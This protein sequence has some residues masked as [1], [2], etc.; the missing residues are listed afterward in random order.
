MGNREHTF[1]MRVCV[2]KINKHNKLNKETK[3]IAKERETK[4][5]RKTSKRE[6][7]VTKRER[8][9]KRVR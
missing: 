3:N 2:L 1:I 9:N 4:R 5:E 6:R 8:E 7:N